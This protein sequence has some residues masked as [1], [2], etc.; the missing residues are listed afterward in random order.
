MISAKMM[1]PINIAIK[2]C[3]SVM[4]NI[5]NTCV[6]ILGT[7]TRDRIYT[8]PGSTLT[9]AYKIAQLSNGFWCIN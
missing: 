7:R 5:L 2:T 8:K 1:I 4:P 3:A 6:V 9:R